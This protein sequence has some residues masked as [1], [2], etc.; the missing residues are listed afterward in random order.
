ML[1]RIA[2][3]WKAVTAGVGAAAVA[4][5]AYAP[6]WDDEVALAVGLVGAVGVALAVAVKK[7][8]PKPRRR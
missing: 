2:H 5:V 1:K 6:S 4:I 7:N 3:Y 8:A